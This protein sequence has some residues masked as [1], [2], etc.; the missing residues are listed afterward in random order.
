MRV[1]RE[2]ALAHAPYLSLL[3]CIASGNEYVQ[4]QDI[5]SKFVAPDTLIPHHMSLS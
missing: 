4:K 2:R 5:F 1:A 3:S